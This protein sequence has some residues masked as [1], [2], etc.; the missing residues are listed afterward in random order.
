[1][2]RI[3]G[4]VA[5]AA[6]ALMALGG[7]TACGSGGS[8]AV[9]GGASGGGNTVTLVSWGTNEQINLFKTTLSQFTQKTGIHVNIIQQPS[10]EYVQKVDAEVLS[11]TLPD[12]FWCQNSLEQELGSQGHLY[13]WSSYM[14]G[15]AKGASST[16]LAAS[17]FSAG[18]LDLY[19]GANGALY[20]VPNESNTYGVF[21]NADL[22]KK[23]HVPLPTAHWTWPQMIA[24]A[25]ALTGAVSAHKGPG[26][27]TVWS[28]LESPNGVS[29][30]SVDNGGKPL[31]EPS[32]LVGVKKV[33]VGPKFMQGAALLRNAIKHGWITGPTFTGN[34]TEAE[35][36]NGQVPMVFGGQWIASDFFN[37]KPKMHWGYAPLPAGTT[38]QYAPAESNGFCSPS[39]LKN[40][41]ATWKVIS[42]MDAHGFNYAYRRDPI[43]PIAYLPGSS[44]YLAG[45]KAQGGAAGAS[46][47]ATVRQELNDKDTLGTMFLG[48]WAT[49]AGNTTTGV[50][51]P[52]LAGSK[53]LAPYVS[54]WV[55]AVNS[56]ITGS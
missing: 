23:A 21:Y 6:G 29:F 54:K 48:S 46:V 51:N 44:G 4:V 30:Y 41:L 28:L 27:Q 20:G 18:S 12:V 49:K 33:Q 53:P 17:K 37:A 26:M 55:K 45:V 15:K 42:W 36:I 19:R 43:A 56:F 47:E 39:N 7:L 22:F 40:P 2:R 13:N 1:M 10:N 52:A 9:G 11:K 38:A 25:K 32:S 35:F 16:G 8:S 24:D 5:G 31:A 34:T 3:K 50:W 14:S